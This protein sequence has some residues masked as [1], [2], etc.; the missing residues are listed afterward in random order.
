MKKCSQ[1]Q[2]EKPLSEF[3]KSKNTKSGYWGQ[4]KQCCYARGTAYRKANKAQIAA[5]RKKWAQEN[6]ELRAK[7]TRKSILKNRYGITLEQYAEMLKR[8]NGQCKICQQKIEKPC[9]D[10]CHSTGLV[11]GILCN[12]CNVGLGAFKDKPDLLRKAA[13]YLQAFIE[14]FMEVRP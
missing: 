14:A 6:K 11:R 7:L 13:D 4:C 12:G 5:S 9:V 3:F 10:H 8:Q 2:K 1:C